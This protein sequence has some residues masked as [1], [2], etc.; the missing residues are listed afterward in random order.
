MTR[1]EMA[2]ALVKRIEEAGVKAGVR[3]VTNG[4]GFE[5][6][7]GL[8]LSEDIAA[9]WLLFGNGCAAI[10]A[11]FPVILPDMLGNLVLSADPLAEACRLAGIEP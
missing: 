2:R 6:E 11:L 10:R 7:N 1:A 8:C 4:L 5:L 3:S 9:P